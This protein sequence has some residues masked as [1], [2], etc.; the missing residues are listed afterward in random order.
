MHKAPDDIELP[1]EM[2]TTD[3]TSFVVW[4]APRLIVNQPPSE[5][6]VVLFVTSIRDEVC[7]RSPTQ[8]SVARV[9]FCP[10]ALKRS[11]PSATVKPV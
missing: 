4:P 10:G 7:C 3:V 6:T 1:S 11:V 5:A 9:N 2:R 8:G